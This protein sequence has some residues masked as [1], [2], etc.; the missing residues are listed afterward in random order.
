MSE[1]EIYY[2]GF[3]SE[4]IK[5]AYKD[6][7]K[8]KFYSIKKF[9]EYMHLKKYDDLLSEYHRLRDLLFSVRK[10]L[11]ESSSIYYSIEI[12]KQL[13]AIATQIATIYNTLAELEE[14]KTIQDILNKNNCDKT[15]ICRDF[16]QYSTGALRNCEDFLFFTDK[17][18]SIEKGI[19]KMSEK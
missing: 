10:F 4:I 3:S 2:D 12:K 13:Y 14:S 17:F 15:N 6:S 7:K 19:M 1:R 16:I 11:E 9:L 18:T 8:T 5:Q